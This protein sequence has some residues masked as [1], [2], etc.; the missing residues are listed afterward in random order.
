MRKIL[1]FAT[2]G[3]ERCRF[4]STQSRIE[5]FLH[6]NDNRPVAHG[7]LER[8]FK[9]GFLTAALKFREDW[10][11]ALSE[12]S[13]SPINDNRIMI[14][15]ILHGG[16]DR[17]VE[18]VTAFFAV[19]PDLFNRAFLLINAVHHRSAVFFR[20]ILRL[21]KSAAVTIVKHREHSDSGFTQLI[22][23]PASMLCPRPVKFTFAASD[24]ASNRL[25]AGIHWRKNFTFELIIPSVRRRENPLN[26][27]VS[28][29]LDNSRLVTA[30][31]NDR[32][33]GR[34]VVNRIDVRPVAAGSRPRN[35]A[36]GIF[37]FKL[38][39]LFGRKR[40]TRFGEVNVEADRPLVNSL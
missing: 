8:H 40:F 30:R 31:N 18:L 28:P 11:S 22:D 33:V 39:E 2:V 26:R 23:F 24:A 36:K 35:I 14:S 20:C 9:D 32:I 7:S 5:S 3:N 10:F 13:G 15:L 6:I 38:G 27:L 17:T 37:G 4:A 16:C 1:G 25:A 12:F 21:L 29:D 19:L 34:I